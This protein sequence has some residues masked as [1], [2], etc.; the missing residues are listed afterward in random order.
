EPGGQPS[1]QSNGG[2]IE[3][4]FNAQNP[5]YRQASHFFMSL[6]ASHEKTRPRAR[7]VCEAECLLA[8]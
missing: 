5:A 8:C 3:G 4:N 1:A 7:F 2:H 6:A